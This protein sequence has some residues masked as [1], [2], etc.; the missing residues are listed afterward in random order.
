MEITGSN[1][2]RVYDRDQLEKAEDIALQTHFWQRRRDGSSYLKHLKRVQV[3]VYTLGYKK[4][5]QILAILHDALEDGADPLH[6]ENVIRNNLKEP[7]KILADLKLLTHEPGEPYIPYVL[8]VYRKSKDAFTVKMA[9]MTDNLSDKPSENQFK[10]YRGAIINL[11]NNGVPKSEIPNKIL[12][13]LKL[14][15]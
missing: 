12:T 1:K 13:I 2:P 14:E 11:L 5:V 3:R 6:V 4:R 15:I 8:N 9:D 7:E 10:K